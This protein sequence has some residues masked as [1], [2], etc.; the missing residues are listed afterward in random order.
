MN[1]RKAFEQ[2]Y[3][4]NAF[5]YDSA[6]IGSRDCNLQW[7]S[8]VAGMM[9]QD[10]AKALED[11]VAMMGRKAVS[12]TPSDITSVLNLHRKLHKGFKKE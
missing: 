5:D 9:Y 2:W 4:E 10:K 11:H 6:P 8:W 12:I 3:T 1:P 7:R